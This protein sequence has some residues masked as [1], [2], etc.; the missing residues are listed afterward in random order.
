MYGE[1]VHILFNHHYDG[2]SWR[3]GF[4]TEERKK[5]TSNKSYLG[6]QNYNLHN[7]LWNEIG[8]FLN[9][10][11]TCRINNNNKKMN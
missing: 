5:S 10:V 4:Q 8:W 2:D 11:A 9:I 3:S 1:F 7:I 6:M